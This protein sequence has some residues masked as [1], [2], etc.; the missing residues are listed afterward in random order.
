MSAEQPIIVP[1]TASPTAKRAG[2]K[3]SQN[4]IIRLTRRFPLGA[5]GAVLIFMFVF[6]GVFAPYVAPHDPR[7]FAG[8]RL[9]SPSGEFFFGTNNLGQD[10][11]SRVIFGAQISL[12]IG[13]SSVIF[14]IS[15]G[16]FLGLVGGYF[17]GKTD[18]LIQRAVEILAAFPGLIL[19]L[20]VIAALGRPDS[21]A[22]NVFMQ[23]WEMRTLVIA[24]GIAFIFP[25]TRI[26][27]SVVL[28][29][30]ERAY[31]EAA[32]CIG[33]TPFRV[34]GRHL[35][36]NVVPYM[37]VASTVVVGIA[38]LLEA[39]LSFLGY[40]VSPGTPSWGMDLSGRNRDYFLDAP[41]MAIAPGVALS[42]TVLGI[43]LLGDALRDG[44]DP[45]MRGSR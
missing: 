28:S 36:P 19:A 26:I 2:G 35:L 41:W 17:G 27:R 1:Q 15:V 12:A 45:R 10:V 37:I 31:V 33:A 23:T 25:T 32:Y 11:Y 6:L 43:N 9:M 18:M 40:G 13:V 30:R 22:E 20:I 42:L 16:T 29:E 4:K 38:I 3:N 44:L 7:D 5:F 8:S 24:I 21:R 34:V 39:A 14:G